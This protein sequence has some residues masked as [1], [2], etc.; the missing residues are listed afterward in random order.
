MVS[1]YVAN[2]ISLSS[3][4]IFTCIESM[5]KEFEDFT[6][7]FILNGDIYLTFSLVCLQVVFKL[8]SS[9]LGLGEIFC[10]SLLAQ[11]YCGLAD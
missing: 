6:I 3:V 10:Y 2:N 7:K 11:N 4:K 8:C 5:I 9:C 1:S